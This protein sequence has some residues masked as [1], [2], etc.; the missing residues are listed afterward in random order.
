MGGRRT[1]LN[2]IES[3]AVLTEEKKPGREREERKK[4]GVIVNNGRDP[5][6]RAASL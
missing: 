1:D 3:P 2:E 6:V 5:T 4:G